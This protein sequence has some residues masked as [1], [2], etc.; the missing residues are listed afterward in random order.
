VF[1]VPKTVDKKLMDCYRLKMGEEVF[2]HG[3]YGENNK[4]TAEF[5]YK[6]IVT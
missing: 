4:K 2:L 1:E 5:F 6:S 3:F